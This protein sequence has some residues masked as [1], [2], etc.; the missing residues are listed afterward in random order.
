MA[1]IRYPS[2]LQ[3]EQQTDYI[4]FY[5]VRRDYSSVSGDPGK[6][7]TPADRNKFYYGPDRLLLNVPQRVVESHS[8][9]W[10][11][12]AFGEV[13]PTEVAKIFKSFDPSNWTNASNAASAA[14]FNTAARV[15]EG[16]LLDLMT[17]SLGAVGASNLNSNGILSAGGG[18]VYNP[19][20]EILYNGPDFRRFNFQFAMFTKSKEDAKAIRKVV[21][22]WKVTSHPAKFIY[23]A[24]AAQSGSGSQRSIP[25]WRFNPNG[26]NLAN[27]NLPGSGYGGKS[28]FIIQPPLVLMTYKRG[29]YDHPFIQPLLPTAVTSVSIDYTPT[30]NYTILDNIEEW[31]EAT[32]VGVAITV[33]L[34]EM[35]N[36]F[37]E[38]IDQWMITKK[39]SLN[40]RAPRVN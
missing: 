20:M 7:P 3:A 11:T 37:L 19:N 34:T 10:A 39:S 28:R 21:D 13:T 6:V 32:T 16:F 30:G 14:T 26:S 1:D 5:M 35:T 25:S 36:L 23:S 33:S 12:A 18:I 17:K 8:Q 38:D 4:E 22:W 24:T 2:E 29:A 40:T 27:R 31:D 9:N 15:G